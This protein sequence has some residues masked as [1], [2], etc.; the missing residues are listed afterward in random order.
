MRPLLRAARA[1]LVLAALAPTAARAGDLDVSP[2]N[3]ELSGGARTALMSLRNGGGAP[4]RYQIRAYR[5]AQKPDGAMDLS[6]TRELAV[7]PPL[8]ELAAG[9][10]RSLRIGT[11]VAPAAAERTWRIFIEEL[12]RAESAEDAA[13]VRVLTRIGVPVFLAPTARVERGELAFLGRDGSRV[14]FALRNPGTVRLRP[15]SVSLALVAAD[16]ARLFER[17]LEA[18]YV[19]A[20]GE[21]VYEV[22]VPAEACAR[23]A[24]VVASAALERG[25]I[26]ARAPGAC[27]DP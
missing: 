5:W 2:V 4:A 22:E 8:L 17:S 21:R 3:V 7:F 11:D 14:R 16:G 25:A 26:E 15:R 18:W 27:R 24:T 6:P 13:H 9:E 20:G 23:A 19:L 1:L 12:P 10:A